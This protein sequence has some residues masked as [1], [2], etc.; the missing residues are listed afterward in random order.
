V[1]GAGRWGLGRFSIVDFRLPIGGKPKFENGKWKI[2]T[3]KGR[4]RSAADPDGGRG[5]QKAI[6]D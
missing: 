3:H 4:G 2:E 1:L 5:K 6:D